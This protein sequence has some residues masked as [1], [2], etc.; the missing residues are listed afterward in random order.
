MPKAVFG[1]ISP[2]KIPSETNLKPIGSGPFLLDKYDQ[3]QVN[4]KRN[5]N[6]WGK[7][8]FGT[9]PMTTIN[10]PI[11]KSNN[12]GDLKLESG[13][14]DASQQFTAQ[15]WKMWE[16]GK[17]VSTWMKKKPYH[18]PGNIPLLIFNLNKPGL[19]DPKVRLAI[20]Y[21]IDYP[22]IATTAMSDYSEP[23]NAKPHCADRL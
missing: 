12:D 1:S 18:V 4:L 10:H 5:D 19:E 14:I 8:A 13:E 17:P 2:D 21:G 11:F 6:Y 16:A 20:A 3:T 9:P 23:A 22:N 7:T 15:I